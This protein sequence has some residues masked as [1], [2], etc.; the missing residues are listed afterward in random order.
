MK[1]LRYFF[2]FVMPP[3]AVL[4]TGRLGSFFLSIILTVLG[5]VPGV[6]HAIIV[7]NDY[8]NEQRAERLARSLSR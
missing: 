4:L 1:A 2:C 6:V 3:L 7:V 5:W 8:H